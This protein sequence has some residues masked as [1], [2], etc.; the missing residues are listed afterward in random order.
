MNACRDHGSVKINCFFTPISPPP[1]HSPLSL[2]LQNTHTFSRFMQLIYCSC[3]M[4][5]VQIVPF[6]KK[7]H[8][9]CSDA[10]N[11][12][13]Y[14]LPLSS[15]SSLSL[16]S[17]F[18]PPLP[19]HYGYLKLVQHDFISFQVLAEKTKLQNQSHRR[20]G[21]DFITSIA[22]LHE[23]LSFLTG[24]ICHNGCLT[25]KKKKKNMKVKGEKKKNPLSEIDVQ[26]MSQL[27][28][29]EIR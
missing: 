25:K 21:W 1:T 19:L 6:E 18:P 13:V 16:N 5:P 11:R 2:H 29:L 4:H 27:L 12:L 22:C 10:L 8:K 9:H 26:L 20:S 24:P 14:N 7:V 28:S 3:S 23:Y 15:L 17:S